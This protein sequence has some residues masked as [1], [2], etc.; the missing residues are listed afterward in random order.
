MQIIRG[1]ERHLHAFTKKFISLL[2][3]VTNGNIHK[4]TKEWTKRNEK[5]KKNNP[6]FVN[7]LEQQFKYQVHTLHVALYILCFCFCVMKHHLFP[8]PT[9]HN[10]RILSQK[11]LLKIQWIRRISIS[12]CCC[13]YYFFFYTFQI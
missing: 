12:L 11:L 6:L 9:K 2:P 10:G 4:I 8:P 7:T 5:K 1:T 13:W 3:D